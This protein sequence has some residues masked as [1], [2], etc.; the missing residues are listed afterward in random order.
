MMIGGFHD[1]LRQMNERKKDLASERQFQAERYQWLQKISE[2]LDEMKK[3]I[4]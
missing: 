2:T 4:K 1:S 3:R